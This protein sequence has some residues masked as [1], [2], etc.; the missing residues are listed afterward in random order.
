VRISAISETFLGSI[1]GRALISRLRSTKL[2]SL[3]K[4]ASGGTVTR[5]LRLARDGESCFGTDFFVKGRVVLL[6]GPFRA[7]SAYVGLFDASGACER[8][9][10]RPVLLINVAKSAFTMVFNT[11]VDIC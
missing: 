8:L 3:C 6:E 5:T 4:R 10:T 1:Q 11:S 9:E 2:S 7:L